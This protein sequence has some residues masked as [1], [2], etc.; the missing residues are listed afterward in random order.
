MINTA[1]ET[2]S[3]PKGVDSGINL[4]VSK[5]GHYVPNGT[6]GDLLIHVKVKAHPYFRRE[7]SDI[8]T[9]LFVSVSQVS[10]NF[11]FKGL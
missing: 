1:K 5:K 2:I 6:P 3:V 4:R 11:C 9:D 10:L 8:H 7:G